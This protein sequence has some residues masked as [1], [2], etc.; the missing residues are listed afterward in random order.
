M[1]PTCILILSHTCDHVRMVQSLHLKTRLRCKRSFVTGPRHRRW[2]H[3]AKPQRASRRPILGRLN[4][5]ADWRGELQ[6]QGNKFPPVGSPPE[7]WGE[8]VGKRIS[9]TT[10]LVLPSSSSL[11]ISCS[12]R[13]LCWY[14]ICR[15]PRYSCAPPTL[16]FFEPPIHEI[17][18]RR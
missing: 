11:P 5:T 13:S 10:L 1:A 2:R 18:S 15:S 9:V 17:C 7:Q 16:I 8:S 14:L 4:S 3:S 12:V 6:H